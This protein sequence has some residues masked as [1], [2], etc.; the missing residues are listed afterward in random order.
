MTPQ[1]SGTRWGHIHS[2]YGG[3]DIKHPLD[4][5][6][7]IQFLIIKNDNDDDNAVAGLYQ[8]QVRYYI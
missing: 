7:R 5:E 8:S 1:I 6:K 2:D 3:G 4:K